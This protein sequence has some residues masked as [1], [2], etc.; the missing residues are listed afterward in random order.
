MNGRHGEDD[1]QTHRSLEPTSALGATSGLAANAA[2]FNHL[3]GA[4]EY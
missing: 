4:A 2:S 3:V 1:D